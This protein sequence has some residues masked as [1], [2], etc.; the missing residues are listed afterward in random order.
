MQKYLTE[1]EEYS[2]G[3]SL[4]LWT[5]RRPAYKILAP[6]V[7]DLNSAPASQAFVDRIFTL[8]GLLTVDLLVKH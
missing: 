8:C 2:A 5:A 3:N 7:I 4:E 6:L 1:V